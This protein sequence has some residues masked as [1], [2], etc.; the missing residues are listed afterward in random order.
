MFTLIYSNINVELK[1]SKNNALN[2]CLVVS[3][4]VLIIV[5][6]NVDCDLFV[7]ILLQFQYFYCVSHNVRFYIF[8]ILLSKRRKT[9]VIL[10]KTKEKNMLDSVCT[11]YHHCWYLLSIVKFN[12]NVQMEQFLK[13]NAQINF[14]KFFSF[15]P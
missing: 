9:V 14:Y 15:Y 4:C 3:S 11:S 8:A 2:R 10:M 13:S 1:F 7:A 6:Q 5:T 12:V